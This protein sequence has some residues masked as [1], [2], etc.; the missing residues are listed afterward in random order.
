MADTDDPFK[1]AEQSTVIRPRPGAGRR[2]PGD[3]AQRPTVVPS[4]QAEPPPMPARAVEILGSGVNPL[5]RAAT[6]LL[7]LSGQIRSMAVGDVAALR[8][9]ALE[10]IRRFEQQARAAGIGDKAVLQARYALCAVLD[11]AVLSTP[12]GAHSE[13]TQQTLLVALHREAWGGERFFDFIKQMTGNAAESIDL[14]EL[15]YLCVAFGFTGK[16]RVR[17]DGQERL[18]AIQHGLYRLIREHRGVPSP[19]LSL[20]WAGVQDRRNPLLKYVPWWVV[21]AA[22]LGVLAITFTYFKSS[23]R[24]LTAPVQAD[25]AAA[26]AEPDDE[27]APVESSRL[28]PLLNGLPPDQVTVTERGGRTVVTLVGS[29]FGSGSAS[30]NTSYLETLRKIG[31]AMQQVPG[32]VIVRGHTDSQ[33]I[34]SFDYADNF[35]LSRARAQSV[36]RAIGPA[37]ARARIEG[38]GDS[39]PIVRPEANADDRMK[40]RRVEIEHTAGL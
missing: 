1:P 3:A 9:H 2:G 14:I 39:R 25:L 30:V 6:P 4:R 7:L 33:P 35:E 13:W 27:P 37:A 21:G 23:L 38:L 29:L 36:V 34:S 15:Q 5:V 8:R 16:Y 18:A 12:W 24:D 32:R 31:A 40:N 19:E 26:P 20:R 11:E 10:E 22:A 28:K 17:P